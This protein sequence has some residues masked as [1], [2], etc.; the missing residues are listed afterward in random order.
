MISADF[1]QP[2]MVEILDNEDMYNYKLRPAL[3]GRLNV[4][5][6]GVVM[7]GFIDTLVAQVNR[8]PKIE[9]DD[10]KG[11]NLKG[12]KKINAAWERDSKKIRLNMKD[13][14]MKR[15]AAISGR[16]IAKY[17]AES[18]PN[19]KPNLD[20]VDHLDF[21]CEPNGGGH[22]DSHY[23]QG[24]ENIFRDRKALIRAGKTG[25]YDAGQVQYLIN[26][27]DDPTHRQ[28]DDQYKNKTARYATLGLDLD[29]HN[30]IGSSLFNLVEWVTMYNGEKYHVIFD[31][32]TG[33]WLRCVPLIEDFGNDLAP[34]ISFASPQEDPFN[35]WNRGPADQIKPIA[36]SIRINL[37]EILNN[38][39]KRNWDMKAVDQ[40]I[41]TDISKL[42]WRQD[43]TVPVTLAPNQDI[44]KGIYR[45]ETPEI[46][47]AI[48]L[49]MYLNNMAGEKLGITAATQGEAAEDK[50]G[51][52]KGNQLQI[53]KRMKLISDSYEEMY[54]DLGIRYDWGLW[55][56]A[57][58]EDMV[59]IIS[60]DGVGWEKITKEDTDPDYVVR[61]VSSSSE[62]AETDE[63]KRT[64]AELLMSIEKDP[65][66]MS[67]IN[68][69]AIVE[70]KLRLG[71]FDD[72]QIRKL[73]NTQSDTTD[74][75]LSEAKKDIELTL[76]GKD[77]PTNYSATTGY[78]QYISDY[79]LENSDDLK[80]ED[81]VRLDELFERHVDIAKVNRERKAFM[82]SLTMGNIDP[83]IPAVTPGGASETAPVVPGAT[84]PANTVPNA[85]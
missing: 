13:R 28:T 29:S 59:R 22:L 34:Y 80:E 61:V 71:K 5:F 48:D 12:S 31:K 74:D 16:A 63:E 75:V 11:S 42:D 21:H 4:P 30:F 23:F 36:E 58:E 47:G 35:F 55:E 17:Y 56:H 67:F 20:I 9:F 27:Y 77:I 6:D 39:R 73:M 38:N 8:P 32:N 68:P 25:W 69:K 76:E 51:I 37:N 49:N 24:E 40:S 83:N 41:F 62:M 1:K 50:V 64:R 33:I 19:Y 2:R 10:P 72:D 84:L 85:I 14:A 52:Y 45:F 15:L 70:E 7:A 57:D 18:D 53:S 81:K 43:G 65:N 78:L 46:S 44:R 54:E 66:Q 82:E 60:V 26:A 79:I 3:Q